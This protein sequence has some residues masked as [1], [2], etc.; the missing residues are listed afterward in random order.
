MS[1]I[2]EICVKKCHLSWLKKN[3]IFNAVKKSHFSYRLLVWMF[4][5]GT[6]NKL[7]NRIHKRSVRTMYDDMMIQEAQSKSFYNLVRVPVF[8]ISDICP[9]ILKIPF[10]FTDIKLKNFPKYK[11]EKKKSYSVWS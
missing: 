10:S 11:A 3:L 5:S 7:I 4:S 1:Q 2:S 9:P 8:T 6:F